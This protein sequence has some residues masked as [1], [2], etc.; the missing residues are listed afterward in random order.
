VPSQKYLEHQG[1]R[2]ACPAKP[3]DDGSA[4]GQSIV[5]EAQRSR[6]GCSR[7]PAEK[8]FPGQH[9]DIPPPAESPGESSW[10]AVGRAANQAAPFIGAAG[11]LT[12]GLI[13]GVL[14]GRWLDAK[15]GTD[16]WLLLAGIL[17]GLAVGLY[18]VGR[19]ALGRGRQSGP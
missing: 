9:T 10:G 2:G 1:R 18:D 6:P 3:A 16:P 14:G 17:V 12:G 5:E 19:V 15:F 7:P 13:V 4:D 11:T 8:G